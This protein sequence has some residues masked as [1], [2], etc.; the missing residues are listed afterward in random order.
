MFTVKFNMRLEGFSS[1]FKVAK[2]YFNRVPCVKLH[3]YKR[4]A[5]ISLLPK[6]QST[7]KKQHSSQE[8]WI[9][10]GQA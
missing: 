6:N 2:I 8:L 10:T 7:D 3:F 5:T 9:I 4:D 1:V